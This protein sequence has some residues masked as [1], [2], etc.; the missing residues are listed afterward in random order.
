MHAPPQSLYFSTGSLPTTLS[1]G[2]AEAKAGCLLQDKKSSCPLRKPFLPWAEFLPCSQHVVST[3]DISVLQ[4]QKEIS[5]PTATHRLQPVTLSPPLCLD[6]GSPLRPWLSMPEEDTP[7]PIHR[8]RGERRQTSRLLAE[9]CS[10]FQTEAWHPPKVKRSPSL[11]I[12]QVNGGGATAPPPTEGKFSFGTNAES[13]AGLL[14]GFGKCKALYPQR[15]PKLQIPL[16]RMMPT[17]KTGPRR[18]A[19][20]PNSLTTL[21]QP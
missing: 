12:F 6:D 9:G 18:G 17:R 4:A 11:R 8:L 15:G 2:P 5:L 19:S 1:T 7:W 21:G 16:N 13:D 20:P 14:C 10:P 3:A